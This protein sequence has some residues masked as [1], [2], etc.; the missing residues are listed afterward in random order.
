MRA[1]IDMC[2]HDE[3]TAVTCGCACVLEHTAHCASFN[4]SAS[5]SFDILI[6]IAISIPRFPAT[7]GAM[8]SFDHVHF[9]V[10]FAD[11]ANCSK[12]TGAVLHCIVGTMEVFCANPLDLHKAAVQRTRCSCSDGTS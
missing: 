1:V 12:C 2:L 9:C 6:K 7:T 10:D 3:K 8:M 4:K 11:G 5:A